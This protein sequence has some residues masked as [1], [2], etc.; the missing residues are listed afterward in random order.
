MRGRGAFLLIVV[1]LAL[2][3]ACGRGGG[4]S[5]TTTTAP[6]SGEGDTAEGGADFA[7]LDPCDLVTPADVRDVL[8]ARVIRQSGPESPACTYGPPADSKAF[9][10][11]VT[12]AAVTADSAGDLQEF[13][14]ILSGAAGGDQSVKPVEGLG[15]EAATFEAGTVSIVATRAGEVVVQMM[16]TS[17]EPVGEDARRLAEIAL[18]RL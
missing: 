15:E 8:G 16:V 7:N 18:G 12:V 5:D 2:A 3:A 6:R 4:G 9:S 17:D 14:R 13:V 1:V 11:V 10:P